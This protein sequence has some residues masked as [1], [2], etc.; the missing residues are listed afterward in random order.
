MNRTRLPVRA[1]SLLA[2]LLLAVAAHAD[3]LTLKEEAYI[4]GPKV[5]LGDL[6]NIEG[7]DAEQLASIEIIDAARPGAQKRV[8][9]AL[10]ETRLRS[11]GINLDDIELHGPSSIVATTLH[12][13]I[14]QEQVAQSL[15]DFIRNSM[16]WDEAHTNIEITAPPGAITAPDG[17]VDFAWHPSPDYEYVGAGAFRGELLVD[18]APQRSFSMRD[19]V[20][21]YVD[22]LVAARDVQ[23]GGIVGP[24]DI[25]VRRMPLRSAPQ[26]VITEAQLAIGMAATRTIFP[27]Q[28]LSSKYLSE[29]VLVKRNQTVEI[30]VR[31]GS[32]LLTGRAR[33]TVDGRAG[34]IITLINPE[35]KETL[36]RLVLPDGAVEVE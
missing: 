11:A 7:E 6:A 33:A 35:S 26:G 24:A 15:M 36:Q 30:R 18:G 21:P 3:K 19:H 10:V 16:P 9:A 12:T 23:R 8:N 29:P 25:D 14:S 31:A 5:L 2:L 28:F 34:D 4:K 13:E 17:V 20:E 22:V 1:A 32:L 27:G